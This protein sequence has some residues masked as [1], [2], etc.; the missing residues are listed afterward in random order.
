MRFAGLFRLGVLGRVASVLCAVLIALAG[1]AV[2]AAR[3][4][5][6]ATDGALAIEVE[7]AERVKSE[8]TLASALGNFSFAA[9]RLRAT[10][11]ADARSL[12]RELAASDLDL[13][14][15]LAA[16]VTDSTDEIAHQR[17]IVGP[18]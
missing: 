7:F 15:R 1:L 16:S 4:T 13:A 6:D 9:E 8:S 17:A 2:T 14:T 5:R 10:S 18:I 11:P 3:S 12:D